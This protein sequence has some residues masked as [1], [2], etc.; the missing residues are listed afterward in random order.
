MEQEPKRGQ[1]NRLSYDAIFSH[2][3]VP[4][5]C[6]TVLKKANISIFSVQQ[7]MLAE[8]LLLHKYRQALVEFHILSYLG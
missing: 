5:G 2:N 8:T 4:G 6:G 7:G 3:L 1:N